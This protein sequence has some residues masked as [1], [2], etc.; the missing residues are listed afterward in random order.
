MK[1]GITVNF[2]FSFFSGGGSSTA[3][4]VAEMCR[5]LGHDVWLVNHNGTQEWWEDQQTLRKEYSQ[6][7]HFKNFEQSSVTAPLDLLIEV[8]EVVN[9]D[10]RKRIAKQAVW[11]VRKP[12]L[13]HDIEN[14]IYPIT[15]TKRNLEGLSAI[16][17]LETEVTKDE[18]DYLRILGR[19]IPVVHLPTIWTSTYLESHRKDMNIPEWIQ[20]LAFF[21]QQKNAL[22]AWSVHIAETNSTASSSCTIPLV[23]LREVKRKKEVPL[24]FYKLHNA[25]HIKNSEF[26]LTNVFHHCQIEDL[27]GT[28]VGR[29]R[30][31]D[32]I[33]EPASMILAHARFRPIRPFYLDALWCGIPIIHNSQLLQK[34]G[35]QYYYKDNSIV[36][37]SNMFKQLHSDLL[38]GQGMFQASAMGEIRKK[39]MDTYGVDVHQGKWKAAFDSLPP[40]TA[41]VPVAVKAPPPTVPVVQSSSQKALRVVFTD[42]WDDFNP[43]YNMFTLLLEEALRPSESNLVVEGH[44]AE[45]LPHGEKANLLIF[46]PF[47]NAWKDDR[48]KSVPKAHYT[49]ENTPPVQDST[50]FLNLGYPHADFVDEKYI[51][52]PLWMLEIDWFGADVEMIRN[53]KPLPIDRCTNVYPEELGVKDKFCAFVVTNPCNSLRNNAFHWLS[54]YKKVDSAG[55]LFNNVGDVI[56][57]GLG[58]GGGELAKHNFLKKYKF[59]IA[60]ENSSSQ[61]YT[62]EKLLH[63]KAAGCIPIYWGDP[64]VERDF[65]PA[66]FI[67]ARGVT[68][69]DQLIELVKKI[70]TNPSAYLRMLSVP[71]LDAYKRDLVRRTLA[72]VAFTMIKATGLLEDK[73][74]ATIPKFLGATTSEEA[75][76]LAETRKK[77]YP[78]VQINQVVSS[79]K[80]EV[81]KP[82]K[83]DIFTENIA[84][85]V[86]ITYASHQYLPSL[87]QLLA[88]LTIQKKAISDL[89]VRVWLT[90][91]VPAE[92]RALLS[93]TYA[94]FKF[95]SPPEH[96]VPAGFSDFWSS[97]HFAWKIW[98]YHHV[99]SDPSLKE[100]LVMYLDA[101]VFC[102]RWPSEWLRIA[103][104]EG[105]CVLKDSRQINDQWCHD[106]F[107]Q[108]MNMTHDEK[109]ANQIVAGILAFRAGSPKA[110]AL[111]EEAYSLAK[112]RDL[113]V[114][115]KWSGMR[116]GKP[117]GHRHDQSILSLLA[118]RLN[119]AS[120]PL[121]ELYCQVS[122]RK[123][124]ISGKAFYV[125][126]GRFVIHSPFAEGIDDAY[127]INLDRRKDRME[128][129]Y[130]NNP[131]LELRLE[132]ISAVE[133]KK[134]QL[135][136]QIARLFRPHDFMWKKAIMGCALSH[137][138]LWWRLA[139]EKPDINSYLILEDDAKLSPEWEEK[140]KKA[141]SHVPENYD[142][143]YLGGI[144]PPNRDAFEH[145][146]ERVNDY[147]S[148]VALNQI[149]GQREP[150][151]YIHWCAYAYVLSKQGAQKVLKLMNMHDGYWT[152]ADHMLCNHVDFMNL[153]FLDPLV[154]GCY[155]DDDPVYRNSS[156]N[157]FN[158]IDNFDSDLWNNDERFTM[159]EVERCKQEGN[160]LPLQIKET[161]IQVA[162]QQIAAKQAE[163][164]EVMNDVVGQSSVQEEF[165][166]KLLNYI[167]ANPSQRK[168][169]I[170]CLR[171]HNLVGSDLYEAKWLEE[172]FGKEI[173]LEVELI[174]FEDAPPK[175]KPIV[176]VQKHH[177]EAYQA[178][179]SKWSAAGSD[180]FI[181]HLSDEFVN[182]PI[183]FYEDKHCLGVL[184][185]Y[186]RA[187]LT[188]SMQKKTIIL[189]LGY[190]YTL[191]GGS[192]N[193]AEKTPRLP[194]RNLRWSFSGTRWRNRE[195]DIKPFMT[196]EPNHLLLVD[197]WE[198]KQKTERQQ[199]LSG[200]LDTY[201]VPCM[202]G[203]NNETFRV[204]EALE[205]GCIP[206]YVKQGDQDRHADF[207]MDELGI[208][209]SSNWEEA[210]KL[211]NHLLQ[212]ISLL[213]NYRTMILN[214]WVALKRKLTSEISTLLA[215]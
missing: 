177:F 16:W 30:L 94:D 146:K 100:R 142:I 80:K 42:M 174:N 46:G 99:N 206:L 64:K 107:K 153:Y 68:T 89:E 130:K 6:I 114:G 86:I 203:N 122:L 78:E 84:K 79:P 21:V 39:I 161:L 124:F 54:Q 26:F 11:N 93:R 169:R 166:P 138:S 136:P 131:S 71:A 126:R 168:K 191:S 85:P 115:E 37:A 121:D 1:V 204:Y 215:K 139:N 157:D 7:L 140:W 213:E 25:D 178:L 82:M 113:I 111:F 141:A 73:S 41:S 27:S 209:P 32:F 15:I 143:I 175:D 172:L 69:S 151:R 129:L 38:Q 8:H 36:E 51:R 3:I 189:P 181:L 164:E 53:P 205:C 123:T 133:G 87:Q 167:T 74:L 20:I 211:M 156:F 201:F 29:Q 10:L 176:V 4:S 212:N 150:T 192:D 193:P 128:K 186:N 35:G 179:L 45:S 96:E 58:G 117:Y 9:P 61:G 83:R 165:K 23:T 105:V 214:R 75:A 102:S 60:Y 158:R 65:D 137:L 98:L 52:L 81:L 163:E 49:G 202:P 55:R 48:W 208:M 183:G 125:H 198:S 195:N 207:L 152:S 76:K 188:E 19:D 155:Q 88:G 184:R 63:A 103:Y 56:F 200:L 109:Q 173:P 127:V 70:D 72:E 147:F 196:T 159:E 97:Q 33:F 162:E 118:Y 101:G 18:L 5:K 57:A 44:N 197:T 92:A 145:H 170:V 91:D 182:D 144:L 104:H 40:P 12:I 160:T 110:N 24:G 171:E 47:G 95:F 66:G 190:H 148:R 116:D 199:Y 134:I 59:C 50:V 120:Y 13:L 180:Y 28:F 135:T 2:Q 185:F 187:D 106:T 112:Q 34:V 154:A 108:K 77:V 14:S 31:M 119:L 149:F 43:A 210:S 67:D 194:F 17:A 62:T 22:P 90:A 132:R